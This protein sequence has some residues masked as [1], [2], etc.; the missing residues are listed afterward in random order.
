MHLKILAE[1]ADSSILL[2]T[3]GQ[4]WSKYGGKKSIF[5]LLVKT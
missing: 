4:I 2:L 5:L 1:A 3:A